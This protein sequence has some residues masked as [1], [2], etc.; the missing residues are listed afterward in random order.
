MKIW[1]IATDDQIKE[2]D[3]LDLELGDVLVETRISEILEDGVVIEYDAKT[4]ELIMEYKT[5]RLDEAEYQGRKVPL[6]KPMK[7]DVA[8]SKV[9]VRK[10]N[11]KVVKVNFGDKNMKIK[12]SNPKRRKSFR[13]RHKCANP[14]PR[15]KARYWSCRAW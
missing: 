13:A 2:G 15:W 10:P 11:G 1:D 12:K 5:S 14:G 7:G 9:Y 6:G 8:K 4:L 3:N